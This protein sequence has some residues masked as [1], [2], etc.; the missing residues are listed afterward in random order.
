M[1][2]QP[3]PHRLL[4]AGAPR[5]FPQGPFAPPARAGFFR[6]THIPTGDAV[7]FVCLFIALVL[8]GFGAMT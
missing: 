2:P 5:A 3:R 4:S 7:V 6:G 8:L 1:T